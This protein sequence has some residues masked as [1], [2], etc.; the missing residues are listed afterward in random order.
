MSDRLAYVR[1]K[2]LSINCLV[3]GHIVRSCPEPSFCRVTGCEGV[4]SSYLHQIA[5]RSAINEEQKT[6]PQLVE[7]HKFKQTFIAC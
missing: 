7:I 1:S 6:P 2:G 5:D 4:Y 3:S